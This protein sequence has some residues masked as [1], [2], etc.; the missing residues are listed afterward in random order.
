MVDKAFNG[1][2]ICCVCGKK[3]DF[4]I[5]LSRHNKTHRKH[6]SQVLKKTNPTNNRKICGKSSD[7]I[8]HRHNRTHIKFRMIACECGKEFV[9]KVLLMKH[10][11][12]YKHVRFRIKS[13]TDVG[14]SETLPAVDES[15]RCEQCGK[16]F[17]TMALLRRHMVTH[18]DEKPFPCMLCPKKFSRLTGVAYHMKSIH[19][20]IPNY[21]CD[22]CGKGFYVKYK[23]NV[24][25]KSHSN[26][27]CFKCSICFDS[28]TDASACERHVKLHNDSTVN[29]FKCPQCPSYLI[30]EDSLKNHIFLRH[31]EAK[32]FSC[33]FCQKLFSCKSRCN[34]HIKLT[35]HQVRNHVCDLCGK[36][37]SS[38]PIL[39]VH[40]NSH[41]GIKA[42]ECH[43]CNRTFA[44][45][46]TL[47]NHIERHSNEKNFLCSQ[48]GG[49]FYS[50][51][52]LRFHI[53][54]AH[55]L[56]KP[57]PCPH[58]DKKFVAKYQLRNHINQ[59]HLD[60]KPFVCDVCNK[61]F[62]EA[63]ALKRH[64]T[65]HSDDRPFSCPTC[66]ATFKSQSHVTRHLRN[67]VCAEL[68]KDTKIRK[69]K[70]TKHIV[71]RTENSGSN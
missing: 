36:A 20:K 45:H 12:I 65:M 47:K 42:F 32:T 70:T 50:D 10:Q 54:S 43:I 34:D 6:Q 66:S 37:F 1:T 38:K 56:D 21:T 30:S 68:G 18:S 59:H 39:R 44:H 9:S 58:C 19:E 57:H 29:K 41:N 25:V 67:N 15:K 11:K 69:R 33:D 40:V 35:H 60:F 14:K 55:T 22:I 53:A 17:T 64:K 28:F 3:F 61:G 2:F 5:E 62:V 46:S 48:C 13:E 52:T 16:V 8:L 49:S 4:A 26:Q 23:L 63:R 7:N 31:T 24:H 51:R 27:K 71:F